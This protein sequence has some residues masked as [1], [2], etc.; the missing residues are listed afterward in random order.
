M[1]SSILLLTAMSVLAASSETVYIADRAEDLIVHAQQGWGSLGLNTGV[2]PNHKAATPLRVK[3]TRY[4]RGLGMHA[5]GEVLIDLAGAYRTFEAEVGV[6]HQKDGTGSV[7]AQA[8]VDDEKAFDSGVMRQGDR[9]KVVRVSVD[10]AEELRLVVTDA[11][12]GITCDAVDWG[13]ARLER[14]PNAPKRP[15]GLR[16]DIAPFGK[17]VTFDPARMEGTHARRTEPM[18]AEDVFLSDELLP[19]SDGG[20]D[21]PVSADG[22]GCIG[23]EWIEERF[24]RSVGLTFADER[25]APGRDRMTLQIWQGQSAWQ[26][27]WMPAKCEV[28]REGAALSWRLQPAYGRRATQ[29]VRWLIRDARDVVVKTLSA[30]TTSRW[31]EAE[32]RIQRRA[33]L[34]RDAVEIGV[35]NGEVVAAKGDQRYR[36]EWITDEPLR[37]TVR[38]ARTHRCK[39]DRTVLR[40]DM[41]DTPFAVAVEDVVKHGCLWI[42]HAGLFVSSCPPRVTL[43]GHLAAIKDRR[44]VLQRVRA[45]PDQSFSQAMRHVHRP[46]QDR[47]PTMLSLACDDRKFVVG[48][49]GTITF[50]VYTKPDEPL[51]KKDYYLAKCPYR[52][53]P[54]FGDGS[55]GP[56]QIARHLDGEWLPIPVSSATIGEVTYSQRTFVAPRDTEPPEGA[57]AWLRQRAVCVAEYEWTNDGTTPTDARLTLTS[58]ARN[59][60]RPLAVRAEPGGA[61]MTRGERLVALLDARA[62]RPCQ[63][64]VMDNV[65]ALT[66][67]LE[68]KSTARCV[69]YLPGWPCNERELRGLDDPLRLREAVETYWRSQLASAVTIEVP[70]GLLTNLI[71][72]SQVHCLMAARNEAGGQ[73]IAAWTAADRYGPLESEAHAVIRGM[74]MM[75]HADFARRSLDY[76]I[77]RYHPSGY[78][79]T[80]Y[81]LMGTGWHLW[82]LAEHV[83]RTDGLAWL[84]SVGDDVARA[85]AW[86]MRQREKTQ[87]LDARGGKVPEYGLVPPGVFADWPRFAY[88]TFQAAQY[89]A[90]LREAAR[91]LNAVGHERAAAFAVDAEQY[92]RD[93]RRAYGWTQARTPVVPLRS[94]AWVPGYPPL[95]DCFGEVGGFFPGED[96]SRAWCK[97]AMAHQLAVNGVLDPR[98]E[99]VGRMLDHMEDV[100]FLRGGLGDYPEDRVQG[101]VFNLGGFNKCQPYYR[102]N[103]ELYAQRDDV[104]PFIRSYFNTP[105]TLLNT[106]NLTLWEH[107]HNQGAWNKTHETGWFLCQTRLMVVMERGDDLWLAPFVPTHWLDDGECVR[108]R[109]VPTTFGDV[110]LEI[111]SCVG[112]NRMDVTVTTPT[113]SVPAAIVLRL[114]HPQG[115]HIRSAVVAGKPDL[116]VDVGDD[117]V[118]LPPL[119]EPFAVEV[120]Y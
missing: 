23:L 58:I 16:G 77:H 109:N 53:R 81:T 36:R 12:D 66:A 103:V 60:A 79:T 113:R 100:E 99:A 62:D 18:P 57:P 19:R 96:G 78:L 114:R 70:N 117:V 120:R 85:C 92:G 75:G 6:H 17:V 54:T 29:K 110:S 11:G 65:I 88:T 25:I 98:S 105:P 73:R 71:R 20:Y 89:G 50:Y 38:Y 10:G 13:N 44:T 39:T 22:V 8:F 84:R 52:I 95:I 34:A 101:D 27:K 93:I 63:V 26:G 3:D 56:E 68:P 97:N 83:D 86:I 40:F 14:D 31:R 112:E 41:T 69:L 43:E 42:P 74:D 51:V 91:V 9:P 37:L 80:G 106:E 32:L 82:T 55:A 118:R 30:Q 1:A 107:F 115:R 24:L 45:M 59:G 28:R 119:T 90:G 87:R 21:V 111:R 61:I 7:V 5:R 15:A 35:Y 2:Q 108:V 33:G 64:E 67:R 47:G 116:D 72:A 48:R 104:K 49:D 46:I 4:E 94:G 76:F 102:R